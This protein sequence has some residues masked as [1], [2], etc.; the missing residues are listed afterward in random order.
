M[1]SNVL[2]MSSIIASS[3]PPALASTS[4][5]ARGVLSSSVS[6][7]DCASR[8]AG[9]MVRTHTFR[10]RSAARSAS[11]AEVVVL[12][13]PPEP[14]HTM[15]D[16]ASSRAS[17]SNGFAAVVTTSHH[18]L[19]DEAVGHLVEPTQVDGLGLQWQLVR[20]P[21]EAEQDLALTVLELDPVRVLCRLGG[22]ALHEV[23]RCVDRRRL[24][25]A[26]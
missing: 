14:Q 2:F 24:Q 20:G 17:T 12:P 13:T 16:E 15:M 4:A 10:P 19:R 22:E 9:S 3:E 1:S 6:P 18:A 11:A 21:A 7:I 25:A 5:T 26:R 8:R 23:A